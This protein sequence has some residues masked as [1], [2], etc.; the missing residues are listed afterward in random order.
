MAGG[1]DQQG[2]YVPLHGAY[3]TWTGAR[4]VAIDFDTMTG[5]VLP[6]SDLTGMSSGAMT[7]FA[8][9]WDDGTQS[10]GRPAVVAFAPDGRLFLGSDT[11]GDIIWIAPLDL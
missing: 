6:G 4:V 5:L 10:H 3:G 1:L 8:T 7:D 9:G 11:T 2:V